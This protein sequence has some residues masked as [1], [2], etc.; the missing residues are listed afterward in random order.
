MTGQGCVQLW[1]WQ[2]QACLARQLASHSW[3]KP[4]LEGE[5][6]RY[7]ATHAEEIA[8]MTLTPYSKT[9]METFRPPEM[10]RLCVLIFP[11]TLQILTAAVARRRFR[12][13]T[14]HPKRPGSTTATRRTY[15]SEQ[16]VFPK[17]PNHPTAHSHKP[18]T[19]V[20]NP[21]L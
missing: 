8:V 2:T 15:K 13:A 19:T 4:R 17:T 18:Q 5:A 20:T 9:C 21:R 16:K 3:S 10:G 12:V 11:R 14:L 1:G 6:L 7:T